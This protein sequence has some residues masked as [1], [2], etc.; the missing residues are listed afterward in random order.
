MLHQFCHSG[1]SK[2]LGAQSQEPEAK[3]QYTFFII[4]HPLISFIHKELLEKTDRK[5]N[6][7]F[8]RRQRIYRLGTKKENMN[9]IKLMK[10][11]PISLIIKVQ[12]KTLPRYSVLPIRIAEIQH[13]QVVML[14]EGRHCH[15]VLRKA[16]WC[17]LSNL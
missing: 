11:W 5:T 15:T 3:T 16:I 7:I 12:I 2:S 4:P 17:N 10:R 8:K 14:Q 6:N 13:T 1:H 9:D